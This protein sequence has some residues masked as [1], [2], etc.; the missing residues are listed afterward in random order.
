MPRPDRWDGLARSET[1]RNP[2]D[3]ITYDLRARG[4]EVLSATGDHAGPGPHAHSHRI[5]LGG[6]LSR[7]CYLRLRSHRPVW[8]VA[9]QIGPFCAFPTDRTDGIVPLQTIGRI[10]RDGRSQLSSRS[11]TDVPE[12]ERTE[13][14]FRTQLVV[15]PGGGRRAQKALLCVFIVAGRCE[16]RAEVKRFVLPGGD[17]LVLKR[18]PAAGVMLVHREVRSCVVPGCAALGGHRVASHGDGVA[19]WAGV[20]LVGGGC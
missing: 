8:M 7:V 5:R 10:S 4:P 17:W 13:R 1:A 18:T 14:R 12:R 9:T 16:V 15:W 3:D 11:V 2:V 19:G 6:A 20:P